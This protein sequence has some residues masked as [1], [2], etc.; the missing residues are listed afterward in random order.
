MNEKPKKKIY[1]RWW[2]KV[3]SVI[4]LLI[5][6]RQFYP[7][8]VIQGVSMAP[9]L[10]DG[11]VVLAEKFFTPKRGDIVFF[12]TERFASF[13]RIIGLP[14]EK[15]EIKDGRVFVNGQLLIEP[16]VNQPTNG[17]VS[18][19]L[20]DNQ[21]FVMGDNRKNSSDS[22]N[23]GPVSRNDITYKVLFK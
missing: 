4:T 23:F 15:V 22:R 17:T 9:T 2:F 16:Y 11:N 19:I 13:K 7:W 6:I 8:S 3:L 5:I 12:R 14:N 1:K 21:F 20:G 10:K 18:T